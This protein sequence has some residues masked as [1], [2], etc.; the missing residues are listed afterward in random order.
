MFSSPSASS[1]GPDDPS[2][3]ATEWPF[4]VRDPQHFLA[5]PA[6]E[7]SLLRD[8]LHLYLG[9]SRVDEIL[10]LHGR[11][12]GRHLGRL[13]PDVPDVAQVVAR[14]AAQ[15]GLGR[16]VPEETEGE[17]WVLRLD[18][19]AEAPAHGPV[20][21]PPVFTAG[22]LE[23]IFESIL[24]LRIQ[25]ELT[26]VAEDNDWR[27]RVTAHPRRAGFLPGAPRCHL[28]EGRSYLL[29]ETESESFFQCV[30]PHA[31]AGRTL[32]FTREIPRRLKA[33]FGL[34]GIELHWF[35]VTPGTRELTISPRHLGHVVSRTEE[36]L[37]AHE[38]PMMVF[39]QGLDY[40][41]NRNET[42]SVVRLLE[43]LKDRT[44]AAGANLVI[45]LP[46]ATLDPEVVAHL[47]REFPN[48]F[49][50]DLD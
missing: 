2:S 50:R 19:L 17:T 5:L 33:E 26:K 20:T 3:N 16:V 45:G 10:G 46:S 27:L 15:V 13:D 44:Q 41:I 35:S 36:F 12:L 22:V 38:P 31:T 9:G 8:L 14:L 43:V 23:G 29:D 7:V 42:A 40:L 21:V 32:G 24:G 11:R 1:I 39:L 49:P 28:P 18:R 34:D 25:G 6:D 47:H 4:R 37:A 48:R 30:A